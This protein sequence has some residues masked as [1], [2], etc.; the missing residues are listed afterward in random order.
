MVFIL[1][2]HNNCLYYCRFHFLQQR[3]FI[4]MISWYRACKYYKTGVNSPKVFGNGA[5]I[6]VSAIS[7]FPRRRES[8]SSLLDSRL[9]GND[10]YVLAEYMIKAG[11]GFRIES[12]FVTLSFKG[13]L[14]YMQCQSSSS[15]APTGP[16]CFFLAFDTSR[17]VR[18]WS[19]K[20]HEIV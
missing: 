8:S 1:S 16:S 3:T 13:G 12:L 14:M 4:P 7:S 20:H 9:R 18:C 6:I 11:N 15:R 17:L 10:V 19:F 2:Y 5:M